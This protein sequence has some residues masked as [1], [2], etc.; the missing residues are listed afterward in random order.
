MYS[1]KATKI[2]K[3]FQK[4]QEK[5]EKDQPQNP[6]PNDG[7]ELKSSENKFHVPRTARARALSQKTKV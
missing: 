6:C 4:G 7:Q 3:N 5:S 2:F 1:E